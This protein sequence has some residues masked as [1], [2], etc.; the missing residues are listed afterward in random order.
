MK[1]ENANVAVTMTGRDWSALAVLLV[2]REDTPE[3]LAARDHVLRSLLAAIRSLPR[4]KA[5][6]PAG[7][8]EVWY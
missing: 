6:C 4:P 5:V 7:P 8:S 3:G 2:L 1:F